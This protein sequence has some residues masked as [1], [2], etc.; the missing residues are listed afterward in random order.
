MDNFV[1]AVDLFLMV[2]FVSLSVCQWM[3]WNVAIVAN[4]DPQR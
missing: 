1:D 4:S 2:V 3:I